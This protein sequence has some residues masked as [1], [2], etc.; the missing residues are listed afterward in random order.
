[1]LISAN[2]YRLNWVFFNDVEL[3]AFSGNRAKKGIT[4][5]A[6]GYLTWHCRHKGNIMGIRVTKVS[7]ISA[8]IFAVALSMPGIHKP[9]RAIVKEGDS[10]VWI[11]VLNVEVPVIQTADGF[12]FEPSEV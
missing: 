10:A 3:S 1:M 12:V 9:V 2:E 4:D 7:V 11:D 8:G 5:S 6:K